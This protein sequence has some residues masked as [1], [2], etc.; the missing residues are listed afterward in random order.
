[1]FKPDST[2]LKFPVSERSLLPLTEAQPGRKFLR[3]GKHVREHHTIPRDP[4]EVPP[5]RGC[6]EKILSISHHGTPEP[7]ATQLGK[8]GNVLFSVI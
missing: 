7:I 1:M 5:V 2:E 3:Y 8:M 4:L 6:V